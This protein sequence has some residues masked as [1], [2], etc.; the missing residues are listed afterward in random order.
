M[1]RHE[2]VSCDSCL[3]GN[4]RGRRYKC[5]VCYDYDLCASC[6]EGGASTTRHLTDHPMQCILTRSD[7]ELYYGGEGVSVEQPQS[8]TCPYCTKM[9]FTEATLQEHVAADHPDTSFEVVCP[10][11]AAVPGGD[12]NHVTD[13][14]AGHLTLEHRSGPR[15]LISFL[16][17]PSASRHGVRRIPHPSRAVGAPRARRSNM[18]FSSSG[19][20]SPSNREGIDPIAELLSQLSGVR[21]SGG[22]SGQSSSAPSQLQQ[23]Q[24]QLQL[25]RQQVRAARQQ[26]ERLPRRQTQVIGSVSGGS[27]TGSGGSGG[28]STT[29][30]TSNS[31]SSNNNAT[32]TANPSGVSSIN[33]QNIMFLLPRCIATTLSDSQLQNIERESANKSLFARELI[34]GT[35]SETLL[36]LMQQQCTVQTPASSATTATTSPETPNANTS[37]IS[38]KKLSLVQEAKRDQ[39]ISKHVTSQASIQ[40]KESHILQAAAAAAAAAATGSMSSGLQNQGLPPNPNSIATQ[41]PPIVQTLMHSVLPQPLVLQQPLPPPIRN[42]GTGTI[43]EPIAASAPAYLRGGVGSVGVT[44]SSR[45][46]PVR[47]VDGRNQSTEPPPPH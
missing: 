30:V 40:Q 22:G 46:K 1:S 7:F 26:L 47:A 19:G 43:R 15:D 18:H 6:Y 10:V 11:C 24:M 39:A 36:E 12:P 25:E 29:M 16:D 34:V 8:L 4:F 37:I 3:K 33:S 21:R 31:A 9:G 17:E 23:L 44:G 45:R 32:N 20:L 38:T 13:D 28:H 5:L 42:T 2:G 41:N 14:F 35:L 27:G